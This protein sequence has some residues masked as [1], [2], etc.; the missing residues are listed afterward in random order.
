MFNNLFK[1]E[2]IIQYKIKI[3]IWVRKQLSILDL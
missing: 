1:I 2:V 3:L